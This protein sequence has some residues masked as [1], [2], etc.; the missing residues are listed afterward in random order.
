MYFK[1]IKRERERES[2]HALKTCLP[3]NIFFLFIRMLLIPPKTFDHRGRKLSPPM[4]KV[5]SPA[6]ES[7]GRK[8][9][10]T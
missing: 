5:N 3:P 7:N 2:V 9:L 8:D 4:R 1:L 10:F 6:R